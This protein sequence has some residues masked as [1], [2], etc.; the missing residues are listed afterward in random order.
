MRPIYQ[1]GRAFRLPGEAAGFADG[2]RCGRELR[3]NRIERSPVAR[4]ERKI[5]LAD[6]PAGARLSQ[7]LPVPR[8]AVF[9]PPR[10]IARQVGR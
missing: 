7:L 9:G 6:D 8:R 4:P 3:R 1:L 2:A 10:P 5:A